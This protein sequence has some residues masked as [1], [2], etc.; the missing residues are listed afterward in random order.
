MEMCNINLK[1]K[2]WCYMDCNESTQF[3]VAWVLQLT[4]C[5]CLFRHLSRITEHL[6]AQYKLQTGTHTAV[7]TLRSV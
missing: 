4:V 3:M 5:F 1:K 6:H 7:Q 2:V